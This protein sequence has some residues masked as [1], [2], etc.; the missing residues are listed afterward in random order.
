MG[1][2]RIVG[3]RDPARLER[4]IV[5]AIACTSVAELISEP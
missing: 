3:E 5:R 4:W 2:D 1:R